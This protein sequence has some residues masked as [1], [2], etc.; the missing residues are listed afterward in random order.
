M[1]EV[2]H[3]EAKLVP[4]KSSWKKRLAI[5]AA[6]VAV[7]FVALAAYGYH[8]L[9]V[10]NAVKGKAYLLAAK[11]ADMNN[12]DNLGYVIFG[13]DD[14]AGRVVY[15]RSASDAKEL[16]DNSGTFTSYWKNTDQNTLSDYPQH[17]YTATR[18]SLKITGSDTS[19]NES[20]AELR[21]NDAT[22]ENN[23]D[24]EGQG[25]VLIRRDDGYTY[26][27]VEMVLRPVDD[28]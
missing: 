2:Q 1:S 21:M 4:K 12:Y 6:V 26:P 15:A 17:R 22:V 14:N 19:G 10:A 11:T 20:V 13:D 18:D 8:E 23:D 27:K 9:S 5:I 25:K 16:A 28:D 24:I 3:T 7:V